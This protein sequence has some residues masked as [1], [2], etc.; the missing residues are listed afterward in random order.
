MGRFS[1]SLISAILDL[2]TMKLFFI[3]HGQTNDNANGIV[4]GWLDTDINDNGHE[5]ARVAVENF[6]QE[7]DIIYSSDLNR[8]RQTASY[9]RDKYPEVEYKEDGRLRERYL[10][11]AQGGEKTRE[12]WADVVAHQE[13]PE[14]F[15]AETLE[16]FSDRINS[17]LEDLKKEPFK[18][19]LIVSHGGTIA[20]ALKLLNSGFEG[21]VSNSK[22]IEVE[23]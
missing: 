11:N 2:I 6:N 18:N 1:S 5:Q 14:I 20:R 21:E 23:I 13:V 12:D 8:C 3:R 19:V 17:F 7:I 9:F 4:Q 16:Q 22:V 10:G 15:G